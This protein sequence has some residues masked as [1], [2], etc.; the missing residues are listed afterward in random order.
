MP[1]TGAPVF[2]EDGIIMTDEEGVELTHEPEETTIPTTAEGDTTG[3]PRVIPSSTNTT[4]ANRNLVNKY[5][6]FSLVNVL[7]VSRDF[8]DAGLFEENPIE[9]GRELSAFI[10]HGTHSEMLDRQAEETQT[11][12]NGDPVLDEFGIPVPMYEYVIYAHPLATKE[13]IHTAMYAVSVSSKVSVMRSMEILTLMNTNSRFKNTFKYGVLGTHYIYNEDGLIERINYDYMID[14]EYTGNLFIA[15]LA[16]GDHPNRW[17]MAKA[18]NLNLV[19]SVFLQFNFERERLTEE[20]E[21]NIPAINELSRRLYYILINLDIPY[22]YEGLNDYIANYVEPEFAEAG[23]P[24]L[25]TEIRLQT[26]PG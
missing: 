2:D 15:D 3:R 6:H 24:E 12:E 26:N 1:V 7:N 8:K 13:E 10:F 25:L 4:P 5:T 22:G 16:V 19:N 9:P 20:S 18:H 11:D 17:E 14:E 21:A 23:W